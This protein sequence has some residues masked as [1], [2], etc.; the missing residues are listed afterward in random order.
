MTCNHSCVESDSVEG[1]Y[2]SKL[3]LFGEDLDVC[4]EGRWRRPCPGK[5]TGA[6]LSQCLDRREPRAGGESMLVGSLE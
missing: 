2:F 4:G 5:K 3:W 1:R 6:A